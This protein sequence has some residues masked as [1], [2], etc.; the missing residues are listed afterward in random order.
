[1]FGAR[2]ASRPSRGGA[3]TRPGDDEARPRRSD[4]DRW[5]GRK[6]VCVVLESLQSVRSVPFLTFLFSGVPFPRMCKGR[7]EVP[8]WLS[9]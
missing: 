1:M 3:R 6:P 9:R 2:W 7:T 8:A 5:V 4:A